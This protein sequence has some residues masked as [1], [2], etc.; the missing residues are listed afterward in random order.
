ME[1]DRCSA[2]LTV[3]LYRLAY[4]TRLE[5]TSSTDFNSRRNIIT[6]ILTFEIFKILLL[7]THCVAVKNNII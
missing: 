2:T 1:S 7:A 4:H 5:K 3:E 6:N